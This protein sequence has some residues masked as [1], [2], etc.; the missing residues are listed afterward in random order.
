MIIVILIFFKSNIVDEFSC[1]GFNTNSFLKHLGGLNKGRPNEEDFENA[2]QFALR[3][4]DNKTY[5]FCKIGID[6]S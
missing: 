6:F 1:L 4:K 3:L 2:K 5:S